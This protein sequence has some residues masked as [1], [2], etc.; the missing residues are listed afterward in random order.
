MW[1]EIACRTFTPSTTNPFEKREMTQFITDP[2]TVYT[3]IFY[4][5]FVSI[6]CAVLAY[7]W[8]LEK[9]EAEKAEGAAKFFEDCRDVMVVRF[10]DLKAANKNLADTNAHLSDILS[11]AYVRNKY[12]IL[13]AYQD[14]AINGDKKPKPSAISNQKRNG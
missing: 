13:Q 2:A 8:Q 6:G 1:S 11:R 9:D 4:G 12:G 7:L 5:A 10:E 3:L 14:W